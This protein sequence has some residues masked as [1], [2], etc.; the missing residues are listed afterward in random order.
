MIQTVVFVEERSIK[1]LIDE[2]LTARNIRD[3]TIIPHEGKSDLENSYP[4]KI[5]AWNTPETCFVIARDLDQAPDCKALK[6]ALYER[7]PLSSRPR[8]RVR[9][10]C[11]ELEAWYL[12][13]LLAVAGAGW[14]SQRDAQRL[15]SRA[16]YRNPDDVVNPKQELRKIVRPYSPM[17][18]ARRVA[19]FMDISRNRSRSFQNFM[20]ALG[21]V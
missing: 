15:Q 8:S 16:M 19:P 14:I 11:R 7:I 12:G 10:V 21:V 6:S 18:F 1:T 9:I 3:V 2:F 20:R 13:D 4:R 5:R 17:D